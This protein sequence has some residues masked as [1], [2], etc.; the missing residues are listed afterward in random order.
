LILAHLRG[1]LSGACLQIAS[2]LDLRC[3]GDMEVLP[4]LMLE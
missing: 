2:M 4:T 1:T 3:E